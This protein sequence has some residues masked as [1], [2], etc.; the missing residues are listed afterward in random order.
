[1]AMG[2]ESRFTHEQRREI[3]LALLE[4]RVQMVEL[5]RQHQV[6]ATAIYRWRDVFLEA[7]LAGLHGAGPSQLERDLAL[8]QARLKEIVGELSR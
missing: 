8:Q 7:G 1:M 2:R 3:V 4:G 6:S 5:V